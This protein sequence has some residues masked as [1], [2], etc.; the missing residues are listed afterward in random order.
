MA[1]TTSPHVG[2]VPLRRLSTIRRDR[3]PKGAS[4]SVAMYITRGGLDGCIRYHRKAQNLLISM[5]TLA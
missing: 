2:G 5:L 1:A 3:G 4:Q